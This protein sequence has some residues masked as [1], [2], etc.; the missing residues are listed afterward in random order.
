MGCGVARVFRVRRATTLA[1]MQSTADTGP[2]EL[3]EARISTDHTTEL[4]RAECLE[5]LA[6]Q[7]L[8]RLAVVLGPET[9]IIRPVNYLYDRPSQSVVFRTA[10]GSKLHALR[11][12]TRAAF[13][14]DGI[15]AGLAWSVIV[16]GVTAE[17]S[18]PSEIARLNALN[19]RPWAPGP[20]PH[21]IGIAAWTVSGRRISLA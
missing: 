9:P 8:G 5:L 7:H 3:G 16:A 21:W 4:T 14:I 20:K 11:R 2:A 17:V 1:A 13:E 15:E 19:L 18:R 12:A 6:S 10:P